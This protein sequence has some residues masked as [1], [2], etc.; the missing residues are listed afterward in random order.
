MPETSGEARSATAGPH[1]RREVSAGDSL[2]PISAA[3]EEMLSRTW[4]SPPGLIGWFTQVNHKAIGK[5]YIITAFIFFL[6]GGLE[7]MILRA[8]LARPELALVSPDLYNQIFTMHGTTMMFLFAVPVMEGLAIYLVPMMIGTRDMVFP[9]LNAFSYYVY[10]IGGTALYAAFFLNTAPD[11]GW[12]NYVPLSDLQFS[13]SRRIDVWLTLI[14]FIEVSALTAA[15]ELVVMIF[16]Q[17][18]PGMSL[19]RM[20]LFVWAILVMS[21]MIIFAMPA[22][23]AGSLMLASDRM[24]GTHFFNVPAGGDPLLWQHLFWFF[25]HPEVYI[26]FIPALGI[27]SAII[28]AFCRRPV[29]GYSAIVIALIA[30]GFISFGLWVHHMYTTGLPRLGSNF[31]SAASMLI[32]IPTGVQIFCWIATIWRSRPRFE[33][34]FLFIIGFILIFVLGGLTGVMVASVPFDLQVHDSYFVVAHFHYVL[35]GGALFPLFAA[36][37]FW[38]P[39]MFGRMPSEV[40]GRWSFGLLFV[41][42]NLTFFPM[43][44]LGFEGMPRRIYT[45]LDETGWGPLNMLA[46]AGSVLLFIGVGV[47]VANLLI[48]LR[49]GRLADDNPW[50]AGTLEWATSSPPAVY[51]FAATPVVDSLDPLW[52]SPGS[53]KVMTGLRSDVRE[54]LVTNLL[55]AEPDH[56]VRLPGPTIWPFVFALAASIAFIGAMFTTWS[57]VVG[58]VAAFLAVTGWLWPRDKGA[59]I[60]W[61]TVR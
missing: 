20:P 49:R 58:F 7:A 37:H 60:D 42:F 44:Q 29:F 54:V 31:F 41:G 9:R 18:A 33:T 56:I 21:L 30:T 43:H 26:I 17:R 47:F 12:F 55:D 35:I 24:I 48:S 57:V 40:L 53:L 51:N 15:V 32:A 22:V 46:T 1:R 13:P 27:V 59:D 52:D 23:I 25:G 3:E 28:A 8:Q 11:A 61:E 19:H 34:P 38:F 36:F 16:K 2:L 45:Y 14:T 50:E 10:L 39:K 5:R 4:T 6:L